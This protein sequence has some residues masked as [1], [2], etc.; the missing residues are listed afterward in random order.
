VYSHNQ[1]YALEGD[2]RFSLPFPDRGQFDSG[3]EIRDSLFRDPDTNNPQ[4]FESALWASSQTQLFNHRLVIVPAFRLAYA[5]EY[6]PT[7]IPRLGMMLYPWA[8]VQTSQLQSLAL[9]GNIGRS[10][11][12]P[13][14][15]EMFVRLDG[16]GGNANLLPEDAVDGDIGLRWRT[17]RLSLEVAYFRRYLK[18]MILFAPVSSFLVRADNYPNARSQGVEAQVAIHAL[19]GFSLSTSYTYSESLFSEPAMPLPGHPPHRLVARLEWDSYEMLG[20][21]ISHN[22]K[23]GLWTSATAQSA[24]VLSRFNANPEEGRIWLAAGT[25]ISYRVFSIVA[26]GQNLLDKRDAVDVVGFPL[27][28]AN[29]RVSLVAKL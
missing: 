15:H 20:R 11:R 7:L 8:P 13:S 3:L 10:F 22:W 26:E 12:Y 6:P 23:I 28:P 24:M 21:L 14:F 4:R 18:N 9:V 16:F 27:P 17:A 2:L 25:S 19:F 29:F 1:S 5:S